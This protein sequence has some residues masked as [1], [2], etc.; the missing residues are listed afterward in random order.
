[1]DIGVSNYR[2]RYKKRTLGQRDDGKSPRHHETSY[3]AR[4]RTVSLRASVKKFACLTVGVSKAQPEL[5]NTLF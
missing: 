1:M 4:Q 3:A 2:Q 5:K